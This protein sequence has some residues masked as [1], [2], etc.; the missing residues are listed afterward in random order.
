MKKSGWIL[1]TKERKVKAKNTEAKLTPT[2]IKTIFGRNKLFKR[3]EVVV[4]VC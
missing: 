1:L 4:V 3:V 2:I